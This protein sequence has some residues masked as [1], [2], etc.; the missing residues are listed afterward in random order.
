MGIQSSDAVPLLWCHSFVEVWALMWHTL[1][2][3]LG[4]IMRYRMA[5]LFSKRPKI[6]TYFSVLI[7]IEFISGIVWGPFIRQRMEFKGA[8]F[9]VKVPTE[10]FHF[11]IALTI[12]QGIFWSLTCMVFERK[13][14]RNAFRDASS[15]FTA[16]FGVAAVLLASANPK[17]SDRAKAI[18]LPILIKAI[19]PLITAVFSYINCQ[20]VKN[21]ERASAGANL[22]D[23]EMT[24]VPAT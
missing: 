4:A 14:P 7:A 2:L 13:L 20:I 19:L 21:S 23:M 9:M 16:T 10:G 8:C 5:P 11:G 22:V 12:I 6:K 17:F 24:A 18:V 1:V 3:S 15:V